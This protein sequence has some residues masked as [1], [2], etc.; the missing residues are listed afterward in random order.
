[1]TFAD[2]GSLPIFRFERLGRYPIVHG[3]TTRESRLPGDG[4]INIAGRLAREE[5]IENR[6]L[7]ADRIG[8][9]ASAIVSGRQ[10]HGNRVRIV[11]E[12]HAGRG[13]CVIDDALTETD[14][15]AT[16]SIALPL[17][18]YTADCVPA[19]VYDPVEHALGLAHAGWRGTVAN[20]AGALV[21]AMR[22]ELGC[23]PS[24]LVVGIGPSIGPCCYEVG[25]EV[26]DA[27]L[28][29]GL[30]GANNAITRV[31]SRFHL[32]LWRANGLALETQGVPA[33]QIEYSGVCTRCH[34]DRFFSRRAG[35]GHRGLFATVAALAPRS[36]RSMN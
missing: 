7:W 29:L 5:A 14:A 35:T 31:S 15:L 3:I 22:A 32:D 27:W 12:E 13:A 36:D 11:D 10:V 17:L 23:D 6:S 2:A 18:V 25:D 33:D 20:V 4:D 8:V 24:N 1:M 30:E 26:I 19:I 34:S 16:R 28:A 21:T 9:D